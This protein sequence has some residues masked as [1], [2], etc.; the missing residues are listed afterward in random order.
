MLRSGPCYSP[1]YLLIYYGDVPQHTRS[2]LA[3]TLILRVV[4]Y[5]GRL[6]LCDTKFQ[7]TW[8]FHMRSLQLAIYVL[9]LLWP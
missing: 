1:L 9:L 5:K 6:L 4:L 2:M 8:G 3:V 7:N